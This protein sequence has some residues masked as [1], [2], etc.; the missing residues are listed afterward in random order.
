MNMNSKLRCDECG[1]SI[2]KAH[3]NYKGHRYCATCYAREFK[4]REC[5]RCGNVARIL[6]SHTV[7]IC[8]KC[9]YDGPCLRCG[10]EKYSM[11]K[12]TAYGPVC[13]A[14]SVYFRNEEPCEVCGVPSKRLTKSSELGHDRR[15][16]PRCVTVNYGT[17]QACRRH[18]KLK[19][20]DDDGLLVCKK[21]YQL[22]EITC[23]E[24]NELMPAGFGGQCENCYWR[25][26]L[27][28]RITI[29]CAAFN[30]SM[31]AEHFK[32]FGQWL[33]TRV[34][35]KKAAQ[36][37]NRYL[38]FFCDIESHWDDIPDY[39]KL[40]NHFGTT[41]LRRSLLPMRWMEETGLVITDEASK[42][43]DSERRRITAIQEKLALSSPERVLLD[44]YLKQLLV[45]LENSKTTLRSIRLALT[46]AAAL[47]C[48]DSTTNHPKGFPNQENINNYLSKK[49]GQR[50]AISGFV[51]YLRNVHNTK[52]ELPSA[53]DANVARIRRK[54]L[55]ATLLT[56]MQQ[57]DES[58]AS[59]RK[60]LLTAL[61]YFHGLNKNI[62]QAVLKRGVTKAH[63]DG[64]IIYWDNL[65]YWVPV[66]NWWTNTQ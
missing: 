58:E 31:M 27:K 56:L 59:K 6:K 61:P 40:L 48:V 7:A 57:S 23:L 14:C 64:L 3:R 12:I 28:K 55:E 34:G 25:S 24:C 42:A 38:A 36:T 19:P 1:R 11:G 32:L 54:N 53:T 52:I 9:E 17:C 26:V 10:K 15:V 35:E 8:Q 4:K 49:P 62:T 47:L 5:T 29:N 65:E 51:R 63:N 16:C 37:L 50:A 66:P 2:V 60:W 39:G 20:R 22:G 43:E 44:S 45:R 46:P 41:K 33:L 18:R 30:S 13:N 21:C